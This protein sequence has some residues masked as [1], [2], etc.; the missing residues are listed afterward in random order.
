M[1]RSGNVHMSAKI[2]AISGVTGAG[3]S[4]LAKALS[5]SLNATLI[6]WDDFDEIS[7]GPEDYVD[8]YERGQDYSEWDYVALAKVLKSLKNGQ[9]IQHPALNILLQPTQN[10]IFDDPLGRL[11]QQTG[12][13]IDICFHLSIP[14]DVSLSRRLLRDYQAE[15]KTKKELLDEI[16]FYLQHARPLFFD[17]ALKANADY[18]LDGMLPTNLQEEEIKKIL[19]LN[20][21]S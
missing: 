21:I 9:S 13:Y 4:T 3:K 16:E 14:L 7:T 5:A 10:I 19:K 1:A 15:D 18:I 6:S 2:I 11:H 17:D 20:H 8:W 12:Q